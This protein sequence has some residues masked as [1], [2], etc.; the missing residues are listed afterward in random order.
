MP[1]VNNVIT[2]RA[3]RSGDRCHLIT[4]VPVYDN[5]GR[6]LYYHFHY[7]AGTLY[8][9]ESLEPRHVKHVLMGFYVRRNMDMFTGDDG[10]AM[11]TLP[12]STDI[13]K[14]IGIM[15]SNRM[16]LKLP[17]K[18]DY[19]FVY[20]HQ[21]NN[22]R[23]GNM[24]FA[25]D[26]YTII[27]TNWSRSLRVFN[28]M[29]LDMKNDIAEQLHLAK[30]I[31]KF[32][33]NI[34]MMCDNASSEKDIDRA[35]KFGADLVCY[36]EFP[37]F[38]NNIRFNPEFN[39]S[40]PNV[41][42][43]ALSMLQELL[44]PHPQYDIFSDLLKKYNFIRPHV[45][46]LLNFIVYCDELEKANSINYV[47]SSLLYKQRNIE[48]D[49]VEL[50]KHSLNMAICI[51]CVLLLSMQY[52]TNESIQFKNFNYEPVKI[53][54]IR[55]KFADLLLCTKGESDVIKI[56]PVFQTAIASCIPMFM[57]ESSSN[58]LLLDMMN[59]TVEENRSLYPE[60]LN[61]LDCAKAV[62]KIQIDVINR[63]TQEG[64]DNT[65]FFELKKIAH[66]YEDALIWTNSV[67]RILAK[68]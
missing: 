55:A 63:L 28:Y 43:D 62:E 50:D 60:L 24:Q 61:A 17:E 29:V 58:N 44:N 39:R 14:N 20:T 54:L 22:L 38:L 67:L 4:R 21:V 45:P 25:A 16:L 27:Y 1:L 12:L 8:K 31:K 35:F 32:S 48:E 5:K 68:G 3:R 23:K 34:K 9:P 36:P 66:H 37:T 18:Q 59:K 51:T 13:D 11:L 64:G 2:G 40:Y 56:Q 30:N 49:L 47:K 10:N 42:T 7:T 15:P 57:N 52:E 65:N 33:P 41:V 53:A 46:R 26:I 6:T 19:S